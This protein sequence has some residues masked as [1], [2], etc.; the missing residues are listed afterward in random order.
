[1]MIMIAVGLLHLHPLQLLLQLHIITYLT[2]SSSHP[3]IDIHSLTSPVLMVLLGKILLIVMIKIL[4]IN[5][6]IIII[7]INNSS[8][9]MMINIRGKV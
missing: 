8:I 9:M 6:I 3:L 1:M 4:S 7:I 2:R 5:K